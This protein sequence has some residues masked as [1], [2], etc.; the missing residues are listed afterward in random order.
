[1]VCY[2]VDLVDA[3]VRVLGE[4]LD[5]VLNLLDVGLF[6]L[7]TLGILDV[8]CVGLGQYAGELFANMLLV[9][10]Y[11]FESEDLDSQN[12]HLLLDIVPFGHIVGELIVLDLNE[13]LECLCTISNKHLLVPVLLLLV[14]RVHLVSLDTNLDFLVEQI[15]GDL[16]LYIR[17]QLKLLAELYLESIDNVSLACLGLLECI[18]G[19]VE[20]FVAMFIKLGC[21]CSIQ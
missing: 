19:V 8:Y 13:G 14:V 6:I 12:Y 4:R 1:M 5:S 21:E 17:Q 2:L 7:S 16:G 15:D 9:N 18:F 11:V 3:L 10:V 20:N